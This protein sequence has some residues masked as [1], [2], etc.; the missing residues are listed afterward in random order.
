M[1]ERVVDEVFEGY[2]EHLVCEIS[3]LS[4]LY[5]QHYSLGKAVYAFG[6]VVFLKAGS[7]APSKGLIEASTHRAED[8][9]YEFIG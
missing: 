1:R 3:E 6:L 9:L 7:K 4:G 8:S 5:L 2:A